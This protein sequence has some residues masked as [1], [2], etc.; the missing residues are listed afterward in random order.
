MHCSKKVA[1]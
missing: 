1:Q